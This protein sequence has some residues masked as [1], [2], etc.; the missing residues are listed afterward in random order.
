M[1]TH[2]IVVL[3]C[4]LTPLCALMSVWVV[5]RVFPKSVRQVPYSSCKHCTIGL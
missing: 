2:W 4:I 5:S 1:D 3:V